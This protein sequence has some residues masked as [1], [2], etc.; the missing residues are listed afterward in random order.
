MQENGKLVTIK[1]V[2][3]HIVKVI[4]KFGHYFIL[5][6]LCCTQNLLLL[7]DLICFLFPVTQV[8]VSVRVERYSCKLHSHKSVA[9]FHILI[10]LQPIF[11]LQLSLVNLVHRVLK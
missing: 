3:F 10:E 6:L 11:W 1:G 9:S 2:H 7:T 5:K 8:K 4:N